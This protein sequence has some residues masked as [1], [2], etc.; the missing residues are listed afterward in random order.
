M[1]FNSAINSLKR[2]LS[3]PNPTPI[4][5]SDL[6][7]EPS[8]QIPENYQGFHW[9]AYN[10]QEEFQGAP[11]VILNNPLTS[12]P[13]RAIHGVGFQM[14]AAGNASFD[15]TDLSVTPNNG[16]NQLDITL[17]ALRIKQGGAPDVVA[18]FVIKSD[19]NPAASNVTIKNINQLQVFSNSMDTFDT[20]F[21]AVLKNNPPMPPNFK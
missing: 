14:T 11:T 17:K 2:D 19:E 21:I 16:L 13:T 18:S 12:P 10:I 8:V 6:G 5:F 15:L 7:S 3:M 1:G 20:G 4:N 9:L